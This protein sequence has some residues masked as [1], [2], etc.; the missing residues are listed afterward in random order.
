[1]CPWV[2]HKEFFAFLLIRPQ[3]HGAVC[4]APILACHPPSVSVGSSCQQP[5]GRLAI[6]HLHSSAGESCWGVLGTAVVLF[7]HP[8]CLPCFPVQPQHPGV[9]SASK[10]S[11]GNPFCPTAP[12]AAQPLRKHPRGGEGVGCVRGGCVS[13]HCG[14]RLQGGWRRWQQWGFRGAQLGAM[15]S[16]GTLRWWK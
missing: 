14:R 13:Q 11:Q 15:G 12:A 7:A 9:L 5:P 2:I 8:L 3:L 10:F 4:C 16:L 1:M 6:K